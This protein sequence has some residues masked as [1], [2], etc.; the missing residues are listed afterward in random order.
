MSKIIIVTPLEAVHDIEQDEEV[1]VIIKGVQ[2]I[3]R[4]DVEGENYLLTKDL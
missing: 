1:A 3:M 2:Y 4:C